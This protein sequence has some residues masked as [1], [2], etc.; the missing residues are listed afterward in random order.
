ML[1]EEPNPN[2]ASFGPARRFRSLLSVAATAALLVNA[3]GDGGQPGPETPAPQ[4]RIA[5][6]TVDEAVEYFRTT[7]EVGARDRVALA[8][9]GSGQVAEIRSSDGA[10]VRQ[11]EILIRLDTQTEEAA[12][13]AG[14]VS[15][16]SVPADSS[17]PATRCSR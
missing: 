1:R 10:R 14:S 16:T 6:V 3:C 2:G 5:T 9:K 15:F 7:G 13:P 17:P 8:P 11:G 4:V 12:L